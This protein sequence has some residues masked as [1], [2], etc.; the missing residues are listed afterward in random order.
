MDWK[1]KIM[2]LTWCSVHALKNKVLL[3]THSGFP[4]LKLGYTRHSSVL[5]EIVP[6]FFSKLSHYT[7]NTV[8]VDTMIIMVSCG[9]ICCTLQSN[10]TFIWQSSCCYYGRFPV[11]MVAGC[12]FQQHEV[13]AF[14]IWRESSEASY[15]ANASCPLNIHISKWAWIIMLHLECESNLLSAPVKPSLAVNPQWNLCTRGRNYKAVI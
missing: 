4:V 7:S 6:L 10:N 15:A 12:F 11:V 5:V 8:I 9:L 3:K 1:G 2:T 13:D 14:S